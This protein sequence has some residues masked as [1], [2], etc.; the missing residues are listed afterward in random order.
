MLYLLKFRNNDVSRETMKR[1]KDKLLLVGKDYLVSQKS[2]KIYW[3]SQQKLGWTDIDLASNM[4]SYYAS[5][6]YDSHKVKQRSFWDWVYKTLQQWMFRYKWRK[7]MQ[8]SKSTISTHL[9]F[10]GGVGGFSTFTQKK[11]ITTTIV[12]KSS[13]ALTQLKKEQQRVYSNLEE[14]PSDEKFDL[15]TLW[16]VL[17]HLPDPKETMQNLKGRLTTKGLL[18]LAVPNLN[19]FDANHYQE[20]WA[21]YDLPRHL[22]HFSNKG[23][24]KI[25]ENIGFSLISK[26]PLYFDSFYISMLSQ[27]HKTG[28]TR[29]LKAIY[30]GLISNIKAMKKGNYSSSFFV[31]SKSDSFLM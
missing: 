12:E 11:G 22:W 13:G 30:I 2:F 19:S 21:G 23:L 15:I 9:D 6:V 17:E 26:H 1:K 27:L 10:G 5:E 20:F 25:I 7:I 16:H 8:K 28:E 24:Q 31:F 3:D 29:I 18:V 4:D 14:I